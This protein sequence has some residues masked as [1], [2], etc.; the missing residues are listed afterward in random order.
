MYNTKRYVAG[1]IASERWGMSASSRYGWADIRIESPL[2]RADSRNEC[3]E[4]YDG[5][6]DNACGRPK[7]FTRDSK[8]GE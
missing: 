1:W 5:Y 2:D 7:Y 3:N 4:W 6:M 8:N